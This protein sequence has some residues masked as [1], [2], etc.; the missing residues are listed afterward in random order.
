[1]KTQKN[2]LSFVKISLLEF[3]ISILTILA[4]C[5]IINNLSQ[6]IL[7]NSFP[8]L[9]DVLDYED[10][11]KEERYEEIPL[12]KLPNCDIA[13]L[14]EKNNYIFTTNYTLKK[15]ITSSNIAFIPDY[16]SEE[17]YSLLTKE[18]RNENLYYIIFLNSYDEE[19]EV[20]IVNGYAKLNENYEVIEGDLFQNYE[21]LTAKDISLL[22]GNYSNTLSIEKY[23]FETNHEELRTLLFLSPIISTIT[24]EEA[25]NVSTNL[26]IIAIPLIIVIILIET[27][28][29][30]KKLQKPFQKL[31]YAIKDYQTGNTIPINKEELPKEFNE[32]ITNFNELLKKLNESEKEKTTLYQERQRMIANISHDLKTPLTVISGYSKAFLDHIVPK[33]KEEKYLE[34]IYQKAELTEELINTL[35][36]FTQMEHPNYE[37][38]L[39]K[40]NLGNFCKDYLA[41]KYNEIALKNF[42][43]KIDIPIEDIYYELDPK[44]MHRLFENLLN[45]SLKYNTSGTT[46]YF[47]IKIKKQGI[48]ICIA[49]NGVGIDKTMEKNLFEPFVTS[50]EARISGAGTGL[51]MSISK[52]IVELHH[53]TI[54]LSQNKSNN[55]TEFIIT[56]PKKPY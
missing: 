46:I 17:Y 47:S 20:E 16:Y 32:I 6:K 36:E 34:T 18:D 3:V 54:V 4:I 41:T 5:L 11:L 19:K 53:G 38:K 40:V 1:M 50:N 24:Y 30:S 9:E 7:E 43:L 37:L 23:E 14:D 56:L 13:I 15:E 2:K 35:F 10:L 27:Y 22:N 26:W 28:L 31:S 45:N 44:L 39:S 29:F 51:G 33:D 21:Q 12:Q 8:V 55:K 42:K 48:I 25:L 52:K 49:D